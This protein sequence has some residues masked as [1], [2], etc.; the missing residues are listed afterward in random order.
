MHKP[1]G[2]KNTIDIIFHYKILSYKI[3]TTEDSYKILQ[4]SYKILTR[5]LQDLNKISAWV[6][7]VMVL[8]QH[9]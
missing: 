1:Q 2:K 9:T 8:R 5:F 4:D 7:N 6:V 3:L